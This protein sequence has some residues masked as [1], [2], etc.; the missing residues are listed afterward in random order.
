[1][2]NGDKGSDRTRR[3]T[4]VATVPNPALTRRGPWL[5]AG[6][7]VVVAVVALVVVLTRTGTSSSGGGGPITD[8]SLCSDVNA[9]GNDPNNYEYRYLALHEDTGERSGFEQVC[10]QN[11]DLPVTAALQQAYSA[12]QRFEAGLPT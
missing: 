4:E 10:Q 6:L 9:L 2:H 12:E 5:L 1:V 8:S 7:A 3:H 11:P